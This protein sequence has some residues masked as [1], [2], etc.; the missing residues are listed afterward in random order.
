MGLDDFDGGQVL[1]KV[2]D[3]RKLRGNFGQ[4]GETSEMECCVRRPGYDIQE[5]SP[6]L[7]VGVKV[8]VGRGFALLDSRRLAP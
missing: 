3:C 1:G 5:R 4:G 8:A 6:P 2:S 7:K